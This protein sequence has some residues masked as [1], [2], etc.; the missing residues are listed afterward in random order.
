MKNT[1]EN[2]IPETQIQEQDNFSGQT[3]IIINT[4]SNNLQSITDD[5]KKKALE[6]LKS[7][8]SSDLAQRNHVLDQFHNE[9]SKHKKD[10]VTIFAACARSKTLWDESHNNIK[11]KIA[12]VVDDMRL[13]ISANGNQQSIRLDE[14]YKN[15]LDK[16]HN[17]C[18]KLSEIKN[19]IRTHY[20]RVCNGSVIE[21]GYISAVAECRYQSMNL[22][23]K[24]NADIKQFNDS[25][26]H[27]LNINESLDKHVE[28]LNQ[29]LAELTTQH[30]NKIRELTSKFSE[31]IKQLNESSKERYNSAE[32]IHQQV[33]QFI[34]EYENEANEV[35]RSICKDKV[36]FDEIIA[37]NIQMKK[38][39]KA[40][41][42]KGLK[43]IERDKKKLIEKIEED[44][45][46]N[47]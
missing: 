17:L 16:Y 5:I 47:P 30:N 42:K 40:N 41:L 37:E 7:Q 39:A 12:N 35:Y 29:T 18:E 11:N 25:I 24:L 33:L 34:K 20:D 36:K 26:D 43:E 1:Q 32:I 23:K 3:R 9:L 21:K 4:S 46:K 31:N 6:I 13:S 19:K 38:D 45:K 28:K 15:E 2:Q 44:E 22:T 8:E 27:G 14:I 10:L